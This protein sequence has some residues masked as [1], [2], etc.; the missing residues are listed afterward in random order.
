[1]G[2]IGRGMETDH[3]CRNR[4]CVNPVHLRVVSSSQN[5]QARPDR[6]VTHCPQGHPYFGDNLYVYDGRRYCKACRSQ[7]RKA[8]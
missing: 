2:T 8:A 1:M 6:R 4:Q 5:N 7:R 3:A